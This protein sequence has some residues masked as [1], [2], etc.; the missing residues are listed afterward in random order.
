M[1]IAVG[2]R[3]RVRLTSAALGAVS[4]L[5]PEPPVLGVCTRV[6]GGAV[7]VLFKNGQALAGATEVIP[8][9]LDKLTDASSPTVAALQG[10]MV[11]GISA[12]GQRYHDP[13]IGTVDSM[14]TVQPGGSGATEER[15]LIKTATGLYYEVAVASASAVGGR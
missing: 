8:A 15:V 4:R 6:N 10:R 5:Q 7:S 1:A 3:V 13:F 2:D 11:V 12:Q 14:Y 9:G